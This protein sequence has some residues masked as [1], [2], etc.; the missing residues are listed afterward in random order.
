MKEGHKLLI[1]ILGNPDFY[2]WESLIARLV[3]RVADDSADGDSSLTE[4]R[5]FFISLR[6]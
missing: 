1:K 3:P 5:G 6:F 4:A 2:Q